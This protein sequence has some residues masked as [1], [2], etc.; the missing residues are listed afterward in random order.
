MPF[1]S[2]SYD[3]ETLALMGRAFDEA[4]RV[5]ESKNLADDPILLRKIM[6]LRIMTAATM[7]LRDDRRLALLALD[8]VDQRDT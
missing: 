4:W 5:V 8:A 1:P 6:A 7:G 2:G 3:P